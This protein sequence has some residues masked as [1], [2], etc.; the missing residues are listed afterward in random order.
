[1]ANKLKVVR[2]GVILESTSLSFENKAV[3]NPGVFQ[4]GETVHLFYRAIDQDG[5]SCIGYAKL[6]GPMT[7]VA[8][9]QE[10]VITREYDYESAGVEDPRVVKIDGTFYLTYAVHDGKNARTAYAASKDLKTFEKKGIISAE[11]TYHEAAEIFQDSHLKDAYYFFASYYEKGEG[12]DELVWHKDLILFP[13]KIGGRFV[14]LHRVLPDI[15]IVFFNDFQELTPDF[16]RAH[17]RNLAGE[18]IL[19]NKHWFESR[20]IGGGTPPIETKDGWLMIFHTVEETN[21][22]RIYH[23]SAALLDLQNPL[24]VKGR[25]HEPLFSPTEDWEKKGETSNVVFPTG[26]A[27]FGDDLY[28][29]YGAADDRIAVAS[30]NLDALLKEIQNPAHGHGHHD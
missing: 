20:N 16:W 24:K 17:L 3:L 12:A 19:E 23:A 14:M 8:R 21:K 11:L 10:P 26:T 18:V 6:K 28:I 27:L 22:G 15:Q 13:K 4:D 1:M 5:K 29:Y 25:L 2:H 30:V 9:A 7:V